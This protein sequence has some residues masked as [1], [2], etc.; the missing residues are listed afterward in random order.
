VQVLDYPPRRT[1]YLNE[2]EVPG[3]RVVRMSSARPP[4]TRYEDPRDGI[5]R[6]QSVRPGGR[7]VSVYVDDEPRK[8]REYAQPSVYTTV[9]P[10]R[11]ERYYDDDESGRMIYDGT[12]D[13]IHHRAPQRH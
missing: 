2:R 3:E 11:E 5:P 6:V 7:E 8:V 12:R 9:R 10:V 1:A 13:V 4:A